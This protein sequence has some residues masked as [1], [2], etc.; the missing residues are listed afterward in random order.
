[1]D[2]T[3]NLVHWIAV[4]LISCVHTF[5]ASFYII[6][7]V[8]WEDNVGPSSVELALRL[9]KLFQLEYL[10]HAVLCTILIACQHYFIFLFNLPLLGY[11]IYMFHTG[12]YR[13]DA[14]DF[15]RKV[16]VFKKEAFCKLG[17][18]AVATVVYFYLMVMAIIEVVG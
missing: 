1:M 3:M 18:Y 13:I 5:L 4:L 7:Y 14:T 16:A 8:D 10:V 17:A 15:W 2:S 11:N 12:K 9:N 6:M